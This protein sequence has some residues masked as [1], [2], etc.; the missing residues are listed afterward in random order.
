MGT[1]NRESGIYRIVNTISKKSYVGSSVSL[2]DRRDNHF[3]ELRNNVHYNTHLQRAWNKYG[4]HCF[5][6]EILEK[7]NVNQLAKREGYW[8]NL[9]NV[10][11]R[12]FGYNK[13]VIDLQGTH[14]VSEET[15]LKLLYVHIGRKASDETRRKQSLAKKGKVAHPNTIT[16]LLKFKK[17]GL[18]NEEHEKKFR[19]AR[20]RIVLQFDLE[21]NFI[22][23]YPSIAEADK[24]LPGRNW[25]N[26]VACCNGRQRTCKDFKWQYKTQ[27]NEL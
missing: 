1:L 17:S 5:L 7:C 12:K 6:F 9:L 23:E 3:S 13:A 19:E 20:K 15:K 25:A 24:E 18:Q 10:F 16:T 2:N 22:K 14:I 21:G 27:D 4:K 8:C 26:I 11:D